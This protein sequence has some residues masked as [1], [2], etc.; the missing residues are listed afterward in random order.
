M[1]ELDAPM[2]ENSLKTEKHEYDIIA[3]CETDSIATTQR[4]SSY[5]AFTRAKCWQ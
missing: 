2:L 1:G 4:I 3:C 5:V